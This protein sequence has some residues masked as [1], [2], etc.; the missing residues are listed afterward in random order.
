SK[1]K[2]PQ[3]TYAI[4]MKYFAIFCLFLFLGTVMNIEW[5]KYLI[6][7]PFWKGL[8][9]VPILLLAN[10]C[11]GIVYN[12]SIWY[13]LSGQTKFGAFISIVGAIITIIIN[14]LFVTKFSYVAFACAT[15]A[16]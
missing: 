1:E 5:I 6:D 4:V 2:D 3:K 9:V 14:V 12:L 7:E 13:K 11:L 10:L 16:A 8:K 15:L